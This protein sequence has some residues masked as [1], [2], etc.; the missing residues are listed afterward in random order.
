MQKTVLHRCLP[1][2]LLILGAAPAFAQVRVQIGLGPFDVRFAPDAP[3]P[4]RREVMSPRPDR[5]SIWIGGYWDREDDR[6]A[7]REGRW[8]RPERRDVR[9]MAPRYQRDGGG[10]RYE[11]GHW[12]N[13]QLVV[14]EDFHRN[15]DKFR[16]K[17]HGG[18]D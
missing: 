11:P 16:K 1:L 12:S 14:G 4:M 13:E 2:A 10:Y 9:W 7:W 8:N 17:R 5:D 6:W 18:R 3:P 15:R